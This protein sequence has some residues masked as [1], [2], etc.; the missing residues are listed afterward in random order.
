MTFYLDSKS[1]QKNTIF[2]G[3]FGGKSLGQDNTQ[4]PKNLPLA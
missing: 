3:F 4:T 1:N 2:Y